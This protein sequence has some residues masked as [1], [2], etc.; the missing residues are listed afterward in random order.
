[1]ALEK[2][3]GWLTNALLQGQGAADGGAAVA[4]SQPQ[5]AWTPVSSS[6]VAAL[7][8]EDDTLYVRFLGKNGR[9]GSSYAYYGVKRD[10][11]VAMRACSSKGSFVWTDLR[12][13]YA[14]ERIA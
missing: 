7:M 4:E 6:N 13:K 14:Y 12:D 8:W 5:L 11:A 2:I 9:A 1:V 3:I 10:V